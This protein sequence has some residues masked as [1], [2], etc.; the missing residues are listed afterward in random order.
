MQDFH[1]Y[2]KNIARPNFTA[3]SGF[4]QNASAK[5]GCAYPSHQSNR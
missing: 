5:K 3:N 2:L 4:Q 1:F